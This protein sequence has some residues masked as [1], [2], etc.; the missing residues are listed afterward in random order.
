MRMRPRRRPVAGRQRTDSPPD[1][2]RHDNRR[3]NRVSGLAGVA[4]AVI[5]L[6]VAFLSY[7]QD[8]A[9]QL[10]QTRPDL[11]VV[12][13]DT[14]IKN[15]IS[16][17]ATGGLLARSCGFDRCGGLTGWVAVSLPV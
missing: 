17:K 2:E 12:Q 15:G 9:S 13:F 7:R 16:A 3:F 11:K 14:T 10:V 1:Q 6:V 8:Q 4:I 5:A